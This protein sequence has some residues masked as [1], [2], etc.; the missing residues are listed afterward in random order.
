[1]SMIAVLAQVTIALGILNVWIVRRNRP[2]PYRPDGAGS[3]REEFRSY[4]LP[5][6]APTVV[7]SAKLSLAALMLVGVFYVQVAV[8][9]AA[10]MAALMVG[11]VL[12]HVKVGDPWTKA[13]PAFGM[14]ALSVLV[15]AVR[16]A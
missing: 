12:A 9:A 7:G 14:L 4:G 13:V 2:T 3:I 1:M 5:E 15:L 10:A 8:P 16:L 6:W 11:A